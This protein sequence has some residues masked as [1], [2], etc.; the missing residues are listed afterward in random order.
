M[1]MAGSSVQAREL[2]ITIPRFSSLTP[3]QRLNREGVDA[4]RSHQLEKA[5]ALFYKAYLFDPGDPFTLNN[6]GYS[7]E[8]SGDADRAQQFYTLA[9][10]QDCTA[11]ISLSSLN[12][13]KGKP[14]TYALQD[15]SN[16]S[17]RLNRRNVEAIELLIHGR[18]FEAA[19]LLRHTLALDPN[20]PF[21]LNNLAVAEEADG[22]LEGAARDYQAAVDT[23]SSS[24]IVVSPTKSWR[25]KPVVTLASD[26]LRRVHQRLLAEGA[27]HARA[28][29]LTVRGVMAANADDWEMAESDFKQ[30]YFLDPLNAFSLNNLGY[31][32]ERD[33][34]PET[35][36]FYYASALRAG[37]AKARIGL[38]TSEAA[39]GQH[40]SKVDDT[41][42]QAVGAQIDAYS[43]MRREQ[44]GAPAM[45]IRGAAD[46]TPPASPPAKPPSH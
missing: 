18:S 13:I 10:K 43:R 27:D 23:R 1:V 25:G 35:A 41:T 6:L 8:L 7:A 5:Q 42:R 21:T 32:A 14:M 46:Q 33:G 22:D 36:Q 11:V 12:Q 2:R 17:M 4:I 34:D 29:M 45:V 24:S 15:L 31:I 39:Q 20:N 9:D 28:T 37:N 19:E 26:S 16:A 30:A 38:A 40:L 3:V 44:G